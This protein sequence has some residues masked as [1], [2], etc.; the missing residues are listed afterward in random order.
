[1]S[2]FEVKKN[3][4]RKSSEKAIEKQHKLWLTGDT[5]LKTVGSQLFEYAGLTRKE[6]RFTAHETCF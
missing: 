5:L 1:M 4:T 6:N 3:C 2:D